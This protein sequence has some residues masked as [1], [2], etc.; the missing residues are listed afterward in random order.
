MARDLAAYL[1]TPSLCEPAT[2]ARFK[3]P[4]SHRDVRFRYRSQDR[5]ARTLMTLSD[6]AL[7]LATVAGP[8]FAVQAQKFVERVRAARDRREGVFKALM[9]TRGTILSPRHVEALNMIELEFQDDE[10]RD[11]REAWRSYLDH[12]NEKV[13]FQTWDDKRSDLLTALLS[14]MGRALRYDFG[15]VDIKKGWYNP[16]QHLNDEQEGRQL[17]V[18]LLKAL[19]SGALA[20]ETS[21]NPS[22]PNHHA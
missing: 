18:Q 1:V 15:N 3:R 22:P 9:A 5:E 6:V 12:L 13:A 16:Q 19:K 20:V 2:K 21:V 7:I 10:F 14:A 4:M 17:R 8:V 11:V